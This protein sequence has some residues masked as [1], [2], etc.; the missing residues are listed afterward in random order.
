MWVKA[1][2]TE[3]SE[4][5]RVRREDNQSFEKFSFLSKELGVLGGNEVFDALGGEK[6][7]I[8]LGPRKDRVIH[9]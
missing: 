7:G 4:F 9:L 3:V 5:E 8:D 1:F 6:E 2:T